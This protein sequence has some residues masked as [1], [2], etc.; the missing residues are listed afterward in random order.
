MS[1]VTNEVIKVLGIIESGLQQTDM[2]E[3]NYTTMSFTITTEAYESTPVPGYIDVYTSGVKGAEYQTSA[4]KGTALGS[5]EDIRSIK[6]E[7]VCTEEN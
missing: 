5:G 3:E 7:K 1:G 4:Y 2:T 6:I